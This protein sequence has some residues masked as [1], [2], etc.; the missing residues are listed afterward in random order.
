VV[1]KGTVVA[2][3]LGLVTIEQLSVSEAINRIVIKQ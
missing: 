2:D 1:G 3:E